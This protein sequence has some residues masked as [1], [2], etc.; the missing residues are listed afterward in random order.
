M[1]KLPVFWK[2]YIFIVTV[3]ILLCCGFFVFL[4]G[5]LRR[6]EASAETGRANDKREAEISAKLAA[7]SAAQSEYEARDSAELAGAHLPADR[8]ALLGAV[9]QAQE[10]ARAFAGTSLDSTPEKIMDA[11]TDDL[12]K[13]GAAAVR[14]LIACEIGPYENRDSVFRYIDGISGEYGYEKAS[15]LTYTLKKGDFRA[16]AVLK[17]EM[18]EDG[19]K[20][21]SLDRIEAR[22]PLF[23]VLLQAPENA[24]VTVN[25]K[26]VTDKPET[27]RVALPDFVPASLSVPDAADYTLTGFIYEPKLSAVIDGKECRAVHYPDKTVFLTPSSDEYKDT[28]SPVISQLSFKYS[29]FVAGV[30]NFPTLKKYLYPDTKLYKTLSTFDNRWYYNYDHIEN[31][32]V[33]ITDFNVYSENLVSAHIE[34]TQTLYDA[35]NKIR[36]RIPIKLDVFI[37]CDDADKGDWRLVNVE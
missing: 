8:S 6:Y 9:A 37:G 23:T 5:Y 11:L 33:S 35:N 26:A 17:T 28:L 27:S 30:F 20:I 36:F 31:L 29:D 15:G 34:Y 25:G 10:A 32:N 7:E 13:N 16:D 12:N 19:R 2:I 24:A 21:Y 22:V 18:R 4:T 14:D 1:K 3:I